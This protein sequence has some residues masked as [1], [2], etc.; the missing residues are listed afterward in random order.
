MCFTHNGIETPHA[1]FRYSFSS[2]LC[3]LAL[4]CV[5]F[6][7]LRTYGAYPCFQTC[8]RRLIPQNAHI[9][10]HHSF[11]FFP[12]MYFCAVPVFP[13]PTSFT[14]LHNVSCLLSV[15]IL[16][17]CGYTSAT[18]QAPYLCAIS[19]NFPPCISNTS[20]VQFILHLPSPVRLPA[21]YLIRRSIRYRTGHLYPPPPP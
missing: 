7:F 18:N 4:Q 16:P 20:F 21:Y 19:Q 10:P 12:R 15:H 2:L 14:D 6:P 5:H 8:P 3:F 1:Y 13:L 9:P 11:S 17:F